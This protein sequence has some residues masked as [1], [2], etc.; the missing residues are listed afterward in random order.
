[1]SLQKIE[2][3]AS[4]NICYI[5]LHE[6]FGFRKIGFREKIAQ[7]DGIWYDNVLMERRSKI[8]GISS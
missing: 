5:K 4:V 6:H 7:R 1:M 8:I 3:K 2:E